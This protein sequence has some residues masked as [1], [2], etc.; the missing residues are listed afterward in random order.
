MS[1]ILVLPT[2]LAL[3]LAFFGEDPPPVW[4]KHIEAPSYPQIA[5]TAHVS[6]EVI[7]EVTLDADGKVTQALVVRGS[8]LLGRS[9]RDNAQGWIFSKPESPHTQRLIYDYK[10]DDASKNDTLPP[11]VTFDLPDRVTIVAPGVFVPTQE[12]SR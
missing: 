9:A 4:P 12:S 8:P 3:A 11:K 1:R 10:I 6:G 2:L 7:V 5:R